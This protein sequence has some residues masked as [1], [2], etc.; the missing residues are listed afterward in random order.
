MS[1]QSSLHRHF[2]EEVRDRHRGV[3]AAPS[4]SAGVMA[5]IQS[6]RSV[7]LSLDPSDDPQRGIVQVP[8]S[9]IPSPS[10]P[11]GL[12]SLAHAWSEKTV[13]AKRKPDRRRD[14]R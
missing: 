3:E 6:M 5:P 9:N 7:S 12:T 11:P 10:E 2:S 1:G 8:P 14:P 13:Q 4:R